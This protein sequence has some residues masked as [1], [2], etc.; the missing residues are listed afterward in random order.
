VKRARGVVVAVD[1]DDT[2]VLASLTARLLN[3]HA[4]L[5]AAVRQEE[6]SRILR[7]SGASVV[8]TSDEATGQLLGLAIDSPYRA[9]LI[10][11]LLLIGQGVDLVERNVDEAQ[12][13]RQPPEGTAAVIRRGRLVPTPDHLEAGDRLLLIQENGERNGSPTD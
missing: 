13:G 8:I 3:P 11:D 9:A 10:E 1:R 12:V 4:R 6:N 7:S 5:V 2:A